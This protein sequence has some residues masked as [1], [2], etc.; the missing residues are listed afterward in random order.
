[1]PKPAQ[2][3]NWQTGT[4]LGFQW[5]SADPSK[6]APALR[7]ID[8]IRARGGKTAIDWANFQAL[9]DGFYLPWK[10]RASFAAGYAWL[11]RVVG[12]LVAEPG[13]TCYWRCVGHRDGFD[14][15]LARE[16]SASV[17]APG[18][19]AAAPS[20]LAAPPDALAS[21]PLAGPA[22]S[23]RRLR[24]K[25]PGKTHVAAVGN[26]SALHARASCTAACQA[27]AERALE[28]KVPA[29]S[30]LSACPVLLFS[31]RREEL[32]R[33]GKAYDLGARL[34]EGS[35]GTCSLG[36]WLADG[37][38]VAVKALRED[39]S[40]GS[41]AR[42]AFVEAHTLD[43][44][45]EHAHIPTLL[46]IFVRDGR[47]HLVMEFG[48]SDLSKMLQ[49]ADDVLAPSFVRDIIAQVASALVY[50]H[51]LGLVHADV[52]PANIFVATA[53][54]KGLHAMLG[55]VG[56]VLEANP[57]ARA[58]AVCAQTLWWRAPEVVFG[59]QE[60]D[61]LGHEEGLCPRRGAWAT[62]A[63]KNVNARFRRFVET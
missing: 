58:S 37:R 44:C 51:G 20:A 38:Q 26:T 46:D 49:A 11:C 5:R 24:S 45:R 32:E 28:A 39:L 33:R 34:G 17:D 40:D 57:R 9:A 54:A 61:L 30:A 23:R 6:V 31:E 22:A 12:D 63:R 3:S 43:R 47:F 1:M 36:T 41:G 27:L 56:N 25:T 53:L 15:A 4:F 52:K 29:A 14:P 16:T 62:K 10:K 21:P 42:H 13:Q 19:S 55:D 35:F 18:A 8:E 48:G 7:R 50:L 60:R 2:G 59:S